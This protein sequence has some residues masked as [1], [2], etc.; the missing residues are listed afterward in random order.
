[1][2]ELRV[3]LRDLKS[4][5]WIAYAPEVWIDQYYNRIGAAFERHA[6]TFGGSLAL[7]GTPERG[8]ITVWTADKEVVL[9]FDWQTTTV[10]TGVQHAHP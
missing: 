8:R 7:S 5:E 1:M 3:H 10:S 2:N 9:D 4:G 6:G